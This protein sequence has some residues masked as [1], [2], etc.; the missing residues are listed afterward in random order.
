M[1][2]PGQA[3]GVATF[4][5][6]D[7]GQGDAIFIEAPTGEQMLIDAGPDRTV[8]ARLAEVMSWT[9]RTIDVV[10][11]THV[12]KD[13]IGGLAAVLDTYEVST[14]LTTGQVGETETFSA[15]RDRV[16]G[17]G[18]RVEIVRRGSRIMLGDIAIEVLFPEQVFRGLDPNAA[19][20]VVR[21]TYGSQDILLT[22]DIG[23]EQEEYLVQEYGALLESEVLKLGHHG[24]DSSSS[25]LFLET[26]Q[27]ELAIVSAGVE[28]TYN[29]PDPEVVERVLGLGIPMLSTQQNGSL[30]LRSDG[31]SL[32]LDE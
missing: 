12:D 6:L 19:S 14:V 23:I 9:D 1:A 24:S 29:H 30:V 11:F 32:W 16:L 31:R 8:A 28:N 5:F 10:A 18:A 3:G 17:E 4:A 15:V 26:V 7:V 13:H 25:R 22:G 2:M 20:L 27:P 21:A